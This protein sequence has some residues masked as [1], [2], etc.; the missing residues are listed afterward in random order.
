MVASELIDPTHVELLLLRSLGTG[1][2]D[3]LHRTILFR[4]ENVLHGQQ[5]SGANIKPVPFHTGQGYRQ[6][7]EG[8]VSV[9][10]SPDGLDDLRRPRQDRIC[11]TTV[12]R[13]RKRA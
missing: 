12:D 2:G 11:R 4:L 8:A 6:L 10:E 5:S 1:L 13:L 7:Q 9:K 3:E